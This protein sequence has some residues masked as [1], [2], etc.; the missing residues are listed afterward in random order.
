MDVQSVTLINAQTEDASK[1]RMHAKKSILLVIRI[2]L[3]Y[4]ETDHVKTILKLAMES[5]TH[6][7]IIMKDARA[8]LA[9]PRIVSDYHAKI[10]SDVL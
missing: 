5:E 6:A 9:C 7:Q 1:M 10:K 8:V 2:T 3:S 4:A